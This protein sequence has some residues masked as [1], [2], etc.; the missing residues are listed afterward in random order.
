[1]KFNTFFKHGL[2]LEDVPSDSQTREDMSLTPRQVLE[3]YALGFMPPE[4][5]H[6]GG[7]DG[8]FN[9]DELLDDLHYDLLNGLGLDLADADMIVNSLEDNLRTLRVKEDTPP[10]PVSDPPQATA[11]AVVNEEAPPPQ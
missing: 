4:D 11:T 1:M 2:G 10:D 6:N 5:A 7:Y 9:E 8:E 3:Q